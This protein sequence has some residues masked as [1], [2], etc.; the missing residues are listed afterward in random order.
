MI[1]IAAFKEVTGCAYDHASAE[2]FWGI[3]KHEDYYPHAFTTL[4][5]LR[6][7]RLER[8]ERHVSRG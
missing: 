2:S 8:V 7:G 6:A 4:D 5:E 1:E 3:L